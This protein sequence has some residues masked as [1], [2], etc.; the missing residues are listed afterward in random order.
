MFL[1]LLFI[2]LK[3]L[4]KIKIELRD[5]YLFFIFS[6]I[7]TTAWSIGVLIGLI[8]LLRSKFSTYKS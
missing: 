6:I 5:I 7:R 8:N 1:L 2:Y 4:L 3:D